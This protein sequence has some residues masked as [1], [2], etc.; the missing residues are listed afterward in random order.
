M[1]EIWKE[2]PKNK[3]YLVSTL[4]RVQGRYKNGRLHLLKCTQDRN[5]YMIHKINIDGRMKS[6]QAG[7]LVA[8]TFI[9]NP[10]GLSDVNHKDENKANNCVDNLE[11]LTH[12]ENCNYGTIKKRIS[13]TSKKAWAEFKA[14]R[15]ARETALFL[16]Q[17][18]E[19]K[20]I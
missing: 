20:A 19:A 8:E 6:I 10:H 18:S 3:R 15:M 7:R 4:G 2:Y 5:G 12:K 11:W 13:E 16:C 1:R 17:E 14:Y 9:P